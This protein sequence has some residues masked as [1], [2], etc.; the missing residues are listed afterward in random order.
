MSA[1]ELSAANWQQLWIPGGFLHAFV[2]LEPDTEV[3]Y[4]TTDYYDKASERGIV[5]NDP[6]LAIEWP[7]AA[8]EV[9]LSEKDQVLPRWAEMG[10]WFTA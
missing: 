5:W 9:V 2:T 6:D 3:V 1:A 4:K 10:D 7:I 8:D